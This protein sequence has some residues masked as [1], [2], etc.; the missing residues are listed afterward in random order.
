MKKQLLPRIKVCLAFGGLTSTKQ[1]AIRLVIAY[2]M[3]QKWE[4]Q[5]VPP[6][7]DEVTSL[8]FSSVA[9]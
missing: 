1:L 5:Q 4:M 7:F 2:Y 8:F 3:D 9:S 6:P